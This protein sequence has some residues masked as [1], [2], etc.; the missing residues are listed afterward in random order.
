MHLAMTSGLPNLVTSLPGPKAK[1]IIER[2]DQVISPSYTRSYPLV[3]E[4]GE[5]A[6]VEDADGNRFLDLQRRHRRGRHGALPPQGGRGHPG[7]GRQADPHVGHRLL[8][9]EHG[10]AGREAGGAGARRRARDAFTSAIQGPKRSRRRSS[11]LA[12]TPAA[13]SSSRF[14]APSTGEPWA[15]WRSPAARACSARASSR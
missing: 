5:G 11:W 2:D 13:G 4:R 6:M 10:G 15:R 9:R 3:A 7:A 14:W 12:I 1:A 8:L